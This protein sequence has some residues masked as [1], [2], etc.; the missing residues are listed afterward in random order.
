MVSGVCGVCY[1]DDD[2]L[3]A[4]L[5]R[6]RLPH[7]RCRK[8]SS[9]S[10]FV[11]PELT[12]RAEKEAPEQAPSEIENPKKKCRKRRGKRANGRRC[13]WKEM[14]REERCDLVNGEEGWDHV[15]GEEQVLSGSRSC[16]D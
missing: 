9:C 13:T 10:R 6:S 3:V 4:Q 7:V 12:S 1:S 8:G 14:L 15:N 16:N 2:P 11:L 5:R